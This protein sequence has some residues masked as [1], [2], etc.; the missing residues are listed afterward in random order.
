MN[1][2][3]I[4]R[5]PVESAVHLVDSHTVKMVSESAQMLANCFSHES[6]AAADCPRTKTTGAVRRYSHYNHPCSKWVRESR[7]NMVWL[8]THAF[9]LDEER[10]ARSRIKVQEQLQLK[11]EGKEYNKAIAKS[12]P[13]PHYSIAFINWVVNNLSISLVPEGPLTEFAQ[14]MPVEFKC[15]DS[16]QAYRNLY[17]HGKT[18]LHTWT[19][20]KPPWI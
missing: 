1:I 20:N 7:D 10:I 6:L 9:A 18:H 19:R 15:P 5:C 11:A 12:I 14:A 8:Y 3:A 16:V 4:Y 13:A 17:I 2:F